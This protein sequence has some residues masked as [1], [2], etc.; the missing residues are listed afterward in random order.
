MELTRNPGLKWLFGIASALVLSLA[1]RA[2]TDPK[3][4]AVMANAEVQ[5]SPAQVTLRWDAGSNATGYTIARRNGNS[6]ST[7]A[8]L[9][10]SALSWTD[11]N[12]AVGGTY[13]YRLTRSTSA[14]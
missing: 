12:V 1:T 4:Y 9:P 3:F 2:E 8:T 5:T 10:G 11:A 14:G 13:E 6:W 7:V